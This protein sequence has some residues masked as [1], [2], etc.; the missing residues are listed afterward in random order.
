MPGDYTLSVRV[1]SSLKIQAEQVL[2]DV[3]LTLSD[4]VTMFLKQI[5]RG[6]PVLLS[7]SLHSNMLIFLKRRWNA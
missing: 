7:L 1:D 3:G 5:V 4:A 2:S 6:K